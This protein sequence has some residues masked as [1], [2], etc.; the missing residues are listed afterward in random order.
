MAK[1]EQEVKLPKAKRTIELRVLLPWVILITLV[2]VAS[3]F[4]FGWN[5]HSQALSSV[6]S[7]AIQIVKDIKSN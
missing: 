3:G 4:Y 2:A 1:Q 7:E 6:K 5:S